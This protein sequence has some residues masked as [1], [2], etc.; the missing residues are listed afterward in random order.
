MKTCKAASIFLMVSL[1]ILGCS[2]TKQIK[3]PPQL[4]Y[5]Y[6]VLSKAI[7]YE[8]TQGVPVNKTATFSTDDT[9]AKCVFEKPL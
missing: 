3:K 5:D 4:T 2:S 8:G 1:L 6:P 9:E 7:K